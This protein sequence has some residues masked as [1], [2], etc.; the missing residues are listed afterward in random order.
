MIDLVS[1]ISSLLYD[2]ENMEY[3]DH[4]TVAPTTKELQRRY[5]V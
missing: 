5:G 3:I 4:F 2:S 1:L